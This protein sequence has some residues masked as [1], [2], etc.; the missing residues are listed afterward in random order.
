MVE[1]TLKEFSFLFGNNSGS[2]ERTWKKWKDHKT[3]VPLK[4]VSGPEKGESYLSK[5]GSE[6]RMAL[7]GVSCLKSFCILLAGLLFLVSCAGIAF[8]LYMLFGEPF[9]QRSGNTYRPNWENIGPC[10][11]ASLISLVMNLLLG[12][13][14]VQGSRKL[15]TAWL[16]WHL[17]LLLLYWAWTL[18][19]LMLGRWTTKLSF[20]VSEE[21]WGGSYWH[22][23]TRERR[24]RS[25]WRNRREYC[26]TETSSLYGFLF[27]G[28][29][30]QLSL[31]ISFTSQL[32]DLY[33]K[34]AQISMLAIYI[35]YCF[36]IFVH[37]PGD[38]DQASKC[39]FPYCPAGW[40]AS[41]AQNRALQPN[42]L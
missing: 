17:A 41:Q 7:C 33:P 29:I 42:L 9:A 16:A 20:W 18:W 36:T 3:W 4:K 24:E 25:R 38:Q 15:L 26:I 14:A 28:A 35:L 37:L 12:G 34:R 19:L 5:R 10:L 30:F 31:T 40:G 21:H 6:E 23:W 8:S 27:H 13:A 2:S 22:W 39:Q 1:R 32:F 11:F